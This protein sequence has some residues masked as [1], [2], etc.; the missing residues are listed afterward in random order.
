M[1]N[2]TFLVVINNLD[3]KGI[4]GAPYK[5]DSILIV[6]ADTVLTRS[7]TTQRFKPIARRHA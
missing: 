5:A 4:P 7:T 6:N 3:I 2:L 1:G